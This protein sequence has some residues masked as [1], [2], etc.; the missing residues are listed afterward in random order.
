[1]TAQERDRGILKEIFNHNGIFVPMRRDQEDNFLD[2]FLALIDEFME[3]KIKII[4][5]ESSAISVMG[6]DQQ[7]INVKDELPKKG[8][9][10]LV[11]MTLSG[12]HAIEYT[13]L[14]DF[15]VDGE[16][17]QLWLPIELDK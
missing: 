5:D 9:W 13:R 4:D 8:T 17:I 14:K 7:W 15:W 16:Q 12:Y 3:T 1:M 10:V 11:K 2:S 6:V